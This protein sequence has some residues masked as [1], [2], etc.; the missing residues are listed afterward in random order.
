MPLQSV[1]AG[2]RHVITRRNSISPPSITY[3]TAP[4]ISWS[5]MLAGV[6]LIGPNTPSECEFSARVTS[7][8]VGLRLTN[9]L[10]LATGFP[11]SRLT[12]NSGPR[13]L[14]KPLI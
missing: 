5:L 12:V 2:I 1:Y 4:L 14:R 7:M 11:E 3:Q 8:M 10:C 9:K 6:A 13:D